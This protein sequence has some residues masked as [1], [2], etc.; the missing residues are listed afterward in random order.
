VPLDGLRQVTA[1]RE[2]PA[3]F[4]G[5]EPILAAGEQLRK[6]REVIADNLLTWQD[7]YDG[8]R[9][10]FAQFV[11]PGRYS[12]GRPRKNQFGRL[13]HF[14]KAVLREVVSP[15]TATPLQELELQFT[16]SR[17]ETCRFLV[18]GFDLS[19]LPQ[20]PVQDYPRGLY[21]PMGI[22]VPPFYQSYAELEKNPPDRSPYFSVLLDADGRWINHHEVAVDGPVLH[23]D[24]KD[25]G[26]LHVYL[27]SYERHTL[28]A[29][30]TVSTGEERRAAR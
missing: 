20:L 30:I 26:L 6:R 15:A 19:A 18:S 25:P 5:Q 3:V 7:F 2:V 16:G 13:A 17:G 23:R 11:P 9:V 8:R 14:D 4:D 24:A 12:V 10:R 28:V 27:L 22:G 21:M 1:E 29:H